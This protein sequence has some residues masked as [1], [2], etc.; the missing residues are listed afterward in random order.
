MRLGEYYL[1][2][3]RKL[4][5]ELNRKGFMTENKLKNVLLKNE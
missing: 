3:K 4:Q 2:E 1:H 5:E